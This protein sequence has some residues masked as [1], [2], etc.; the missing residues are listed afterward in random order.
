MRCEILFAKAVI[1]HWRCYKDAD[2][3]SE[4]SDLVSILENNPLFGRDYIEGIP[5][6]RSL[7]KLFFGK[8]F[9]VSYRYLFTPICDFVPAAKSDTILVFEIGAPTLSAPLQL[10]SYELLEVK[11]AI[12][13]VW[14]SA[15]A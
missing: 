2:W 11:E 6:V 3:R 1:G 10:S 15:R 12:A 14:N 9:A 8:P 5:A 7:N 13:L 4:Q